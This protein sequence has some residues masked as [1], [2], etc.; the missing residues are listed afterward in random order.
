VIDPTRQRDQP[1]LTT[2]SGL[3]WVIMGGL[4]AAISVGVL[5]PLFGSPPRGVAITAAIVVAVIYLGML[6]VRFAV[7]PGRRRLAV[8]AGGMITIAAVALVGVL[9]VAI[10]A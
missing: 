4:L 3:I 8:L 6:A 9:L 5:I 7:R 2:S 1:A 10:N